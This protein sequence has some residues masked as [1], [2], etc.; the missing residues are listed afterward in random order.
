[1]ILVLMS[2][3]STLKKKVK[4]CHFKLQHSSRSS[5]HNEPPKDGIIQI[6]LEKTTLNYWNNKILLNIDQKRTLYI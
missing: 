6:R 5:A 1:M 3:S 2:P 4:T